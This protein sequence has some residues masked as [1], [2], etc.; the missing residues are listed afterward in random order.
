MVV[1]T[2]RLR[3]APSPED[4][5]DALALAIT[6]ARRSEPGTVARRPAR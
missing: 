5:T 6:H 4:V 3:R 2:L 1:L